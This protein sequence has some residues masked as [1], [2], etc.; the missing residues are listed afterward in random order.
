MQIPYDFKFLWSNIFVIFMNLMVITKNL[1]QNFLDSS[2]KSSMEAI[3]QK[4]K[5]MEI[6]SN[7]VSGSS[8][9]IREYIIPV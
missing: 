3:S 2:S 1:S 8:L 5:T 7:R 4:F 6:W 9:I